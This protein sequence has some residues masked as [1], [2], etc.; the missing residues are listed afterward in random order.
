MRFAWFLPGNVSE[1]QGCAKFMR[2]EMHWCLRI[3]WD[4]DVRVALLGNKK[5]KLDTARKW[6]AD[7]PI[8]QTEVYGYSKVTLRQKIS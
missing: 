4:C 6:N 5:R 8:H 1:N 7:E 2:H 3:V